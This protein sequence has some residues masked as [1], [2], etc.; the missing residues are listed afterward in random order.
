M[1]LARAAHSM[2]S[3]CGNLGAMSLAHLC[4]AIE[5]G[6]R[7]GDLEAVRSLVQRSSEEYQKVAQALRGQL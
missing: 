7:Q 1:A 5:A 2:K 6:G 3:S 4:Q